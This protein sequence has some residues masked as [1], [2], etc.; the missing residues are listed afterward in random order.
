MT[1]N[2]NPKTIDHEDIPEVNITPE[3]EKEKMLDRVKA[4]GSRHKNKFA[5]AAIGLLSGAASGLILAKNIDFH[6]V[7]D[8]AEDSEACPLAIEE[9]EDLSE[10]TENPD[11]TDD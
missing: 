11:P 2:K 3:P 7:L 6:L 9:S 1:N 4:F 10:I 5:T 8:G